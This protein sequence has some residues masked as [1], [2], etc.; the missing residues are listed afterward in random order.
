[1]SLVKGMTKTLSSWSYK[2]CFILESEFSVKIQ[3][4]SKPVLFLCELFSQ[5]SIYK[6]MRI[7]P[8][9]EVK[10]FHLLC[11]RI[12]PPSLSEVT[13]SLANPVPKDFSLSLL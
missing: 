7:D 13:F 10:N 9:S 5:D 11:I 8:D 3:Q 4:K 1:M 6:D 12:L 2:V